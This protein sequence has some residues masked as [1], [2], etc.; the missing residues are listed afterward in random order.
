MAIIE[1][2]AMFFLKKYD[3]KNNTIFLLIGGSLYFLIAIIFSYA[4][5]YNYIVNTNVYWNVFSMV[6]SMFVGFMF[7]EFLSFTNIVGIIICFVGIY[8]M[9][10]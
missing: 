10:L 4:I 5:Q 9:N 8:V 1:S 7:G 3:V 2:I 6:F